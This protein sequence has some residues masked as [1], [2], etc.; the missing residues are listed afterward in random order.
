MAALTISI[1]GGGALRYW[2]SP[3]SL[4]TRERSS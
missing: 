1:A 3:V 4:Q 2:S